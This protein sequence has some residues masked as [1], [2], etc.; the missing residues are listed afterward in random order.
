MS[1]RRKKLTPA[2]PYAYLHQFTKDIEALL[3]ETRAYLFDGKR[4]A[5]QGDLFAPAETAA[6]DATEGRS[7]KNAKK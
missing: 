7:T 2:S 4:A 6:D 1:F 3:S 5:V